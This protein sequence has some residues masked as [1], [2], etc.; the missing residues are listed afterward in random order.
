MKDKLGYVASYNTK[1]CYKGMHNRNISL[2]LPIS[3]NDDIVKR[4]AFPA[5]H[6]FFHSV[7]FEFTAS[8]YLCVF[9]AFITWADNRFIPS[10]A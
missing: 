10:R 6:V 4:I 9:P 7:S 2:E 3:V 8:L 1:G 5:V